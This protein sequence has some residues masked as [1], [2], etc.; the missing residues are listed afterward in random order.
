MSHHAE[1]LLQQ[2]IKQRQ[3]GQRCIHSTGRKGAQTLG[4]PLLLLSPATA[5]VS[6]ALFEAWLSG[7]SG[8]SS[9]GG[10]CSRFMRLLWHGVCYLF[11]F[12]LAYITSRRGSCCRRCIV[13][14]HSDDA[15]RSC[16]AGC[17]AIRRKKRGGFE[18]SATLSR[19]RRVIGVSAFLRAATAVYIGTIPMYRRWILA[20]NMMAPGSFFLAI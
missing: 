4:G 20:G 15:S 3:E 5:A 6:A 18:C 13:Y 14:I 10:C 12:T 2:L 16:A 17:V 7:P 11:V 1:R 8:T 9:H 19:T